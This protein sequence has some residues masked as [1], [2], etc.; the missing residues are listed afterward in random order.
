MIDSKQVRQTAKVLRRGVDTMVG[1]IEAEGSNL[2]RR[3]GETLHLVK[4]RRRLAP[5]GIALGLL[6]AV[7]VL[8]LVAGS[9]VHD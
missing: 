9:G 1:F 6:G 5:L 7:A 2:F 8:G 3:A 4:P